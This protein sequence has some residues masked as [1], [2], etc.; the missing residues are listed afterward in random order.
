L[1]LFVWVFLC[2]AHITLPTYDCTL[3]WLPLMSFIMNRNVWS[4]QNTDFI[5]FFVCTALKC[6]M[7]P[8]AKSLLHWKTKFEF[9]WFIIWG[10]ISN[11]EKT[12]YVNSKIY[13][14][15]L[16]RYTD[17]LSNY[18]DISLHT[19]IIK[20]VEYAYWMPIDNMLTGILSA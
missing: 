12:Q 5:R 7:K 20:N 6:F 3:Q 18:N 8:T 11:E 9:L 19:W 15:L 2:I 1:F 14:S 16:L 17:G 4:S 13:Y 10:K